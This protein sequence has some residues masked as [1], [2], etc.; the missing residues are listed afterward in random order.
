MR[1]SERRRR[2]A[3][4][5]RYYREEEIRLQEEARLAQR[6]L[7]QRIEDATEGNQTLNDLLTEI[8]E[9]VGIQ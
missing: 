4:E 2:A 3:N 5:E 1:E 9:K 8:C 7:W 6:S